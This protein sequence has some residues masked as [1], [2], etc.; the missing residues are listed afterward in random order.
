MSCGVDVLGVVV[1][2][3]LLRAISPIERSV[4]PPSLRTRSAMG[5]VMAKISVGLLVEQQMV[6]AEMRP[7]TCQWKFL[8]FR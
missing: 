4:V 2:D 6:V 1:R 7:A 8:V 3:A 5:S